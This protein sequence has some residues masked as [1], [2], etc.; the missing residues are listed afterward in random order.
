MLTFPLDP[1]CPFWQ[2]ILPSTVPAPKRS[3]LPP[4]TRSYLLSPDLLTRLQPGPALQQDIAQFVTLSRTTSEPAKLEAKGKR[5]C[6]T[7]GLHGLA[8]MAQQLER[9]LESDLTH[10]DASR[11]ARQG[12]RTRQTRLTL[13]AR[14]R[15]VIAAAGDSQ[16]EARS[17]SE[18]Q[19]ATGFGTAGQA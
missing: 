17:Q 8:T 13:V 11:S 3:P 12:Q 16:P 10:G 15:A 9:T 7:L 6:Q 18:G 2:R 1:T 5:L 19:Q 14:L 4:H